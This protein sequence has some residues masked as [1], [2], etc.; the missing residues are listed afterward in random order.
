LGLRPTFILLIA[1]AVAR[2][3]AWVGAMPYASFVWYGV[4]AWGELNWSVYL[5]MIGPLVLIAALSSVSWFVRTQPW[6][7]A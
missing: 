2:R 7:G 1:L 3:W 6:S 4:M 5:V